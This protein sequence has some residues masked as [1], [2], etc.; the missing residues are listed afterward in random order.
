MDITQEKIYDFDQTKSEEVKE[1]LKPFLDLIPNRAE[2]NL[3]TIFLEQLLFDRDNSRMKMFPSFNQKHL[4]KFSIYYPSYTEERINEI[5]LKAISEI[6]EWLIENNFLSNKI[7]YINDGIHANFAGY[8]SVT[9][10]CP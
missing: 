7:T 9:P 6:R 8:R 1:Y 4:E 3:K 5:T 2:F 10:H